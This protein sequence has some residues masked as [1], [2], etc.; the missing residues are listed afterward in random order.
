MDFPSFGVHFGTE[1]LPLS[2]KLVR[3]ESATIRALLM[4]PAICMTPGTAAAPA[5]PPAAPAAAAPA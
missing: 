1:P 2:W 4:P 5:R 3:R